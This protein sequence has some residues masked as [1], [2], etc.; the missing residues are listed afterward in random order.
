MSTKFWYAPHQNRPYSLE[1]RNF[2]VFGLI[3]VTA[4]IGPWSNFCG[5][6]IDPSMDS[7]KSKVGGTNEH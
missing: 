5:A 3:F 6:Q 1:D 7:T 4:V 2:S